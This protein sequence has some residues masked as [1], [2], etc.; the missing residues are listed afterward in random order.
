MKYFIEGHKAKTDLVHEETMII[1]DEKA[2]SSLQEA[3]KKAREY[4]EEEKDL[5]LAVI[6]EENPVGEREGV[7][8]IH[9]DQEGN[10]E[11]VAHWW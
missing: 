11:E 5:A 9:R 1:K 8:F 6:Y 3:L 7:K 4:F 2:Y 10:L